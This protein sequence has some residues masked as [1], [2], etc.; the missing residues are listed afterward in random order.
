VGRGDFRA[1]PTAPAH[2]QGLVSELRGQRIQ[3]PLQPE[4]NRRLGRPSALRTS[5]YYDILVETAFGNYRDTLSQVTR[6]PIMGHFLSHIGNG[7]AAYNP[8]DDT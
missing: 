8:E 3:R 7:K 4:E 1:R 2:G 6:H 5:D